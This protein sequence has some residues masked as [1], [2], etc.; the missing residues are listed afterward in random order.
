LSGDTVNGEEEFLKEMKSPTN[1]KRVLEFEVPR[2]RVEQEIRGI[3]AGIRKEVSLPGFRKGKVPLDVVMA[4]FGDSARKE[5]I[6]KLIPEAY[7]KALD[8]ESLQPVLPAEISD[9]EY[10]REG[11]LRFRM[12]I[13]IFPSVKTGNYKGV[14]VKKEYKSPEDADVDREVEAL[15]DRFAGFEESDRPA[16]AGDTVIGDYWRLGAEGRPVKGSKV[17]GYPF[18]LTA[19]GLLKEFKEALAGIRIGEKKTVQVVYPE[20][21]PQE[22]MRGRAVSFLVDVKRIGR[23]RLPEVDEKFAK[24]L[25]VESVEVLRQKVREGLDNTRQQE[26]DT[27]ARRDILNSVIEDSDFE[28]PE[29]LVQM[30]LDSMMKS[31]EDEE[32]DAG[33]REKLE[34]ARERL[35]PLAV[36]LVKEQFIVD[37]I[38][39][40]EGITVGDAEIEE[41]IQAVAQRSGLSVEET[42]RKAAESDEMS[43]WRRNVLKN[44]VLDFLFDNAKIEQ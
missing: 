41:I 28:V 27:K 8:K 39:E 36:N 38:A 2:A 17:S 33:A 35:R 42:R 37:D 31:Y 43:R 34:Q 13:E 10:G 19:P 24:M 7:R 23:R 12:E 16:E 22:E 15:R 11:P 5:A 40:R 14:K 29:G 44:K 9:M 6:E 20:D 4:R 25:G 18:D 26:A 21:Y 3:I 30:G 32:G 1:L